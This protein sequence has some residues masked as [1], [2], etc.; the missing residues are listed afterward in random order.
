MQTYEE[1]ALYMENFFKGKKNK[2][3]MLT[4]DIPPMFT[5][6][7]K[8]RN[9]VLQSNQEDLGEPPADLSKLLIL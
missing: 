3:Q 1:A 2:G 6:L 7:E 4:R 5:R 8:I 9:V